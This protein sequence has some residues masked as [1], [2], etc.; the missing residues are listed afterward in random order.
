MTSTKFLPMIYGLVDPL[1]SEH[2]R[3]IGKTRVKER[4]RGHEKEAL[5]VDYHT[6]KI[7][8]ILSL[9]VEGRTYDVITIEQHLITI[10]DEDLNLSEKF[11][12]AKYRSEGHAL[13]NSTDGGDGVIN[14]SPESRLK[15]SLASKKYWED[16]PEF[17]EM[18]SIN[19][20]AQWQDPAYREY[21]L[22][23]ISEAAK[24]R[25]KNPDYR[26]LMLEVRAKQWTDERRLDQSMEFME[27]WADPVFYAEQ[28]EK[29][30]QGQI[31]RYK[32][33]ENAIKTSEAMYAN[34]TGT[35]EY[36]ILQ[37]KKRLK[38]HERIVKRNLDNIAVARSLRM[39]EHLTQRL[40]D[41]TS[42]K[43]KE[44]VA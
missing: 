4:P 43:M 38:E 28:I 15:I 17:R 26:K 18:M 2:V 36:K 30:R 40:I 42:Q 24:R 7:H 16:H 32:N 44:A 6:H 22:K 1:E 25:W 23:K 27:K 21:H 20:L 11:Y 13:T 3:Y 39:I 35:I 34:K 10:S 8:W 5:V 31:R 41:L 33:P 19:A 14:L 12:I 29:Y 9:L 37:V